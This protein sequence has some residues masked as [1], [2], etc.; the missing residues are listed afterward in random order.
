MGSERRRDYMVNQRVHVL[1]MVTWITSLLLVLASV[2]TGYSLYQLAPRQPAP[3]EIFGL[4]AYAVVGA[5]VFVIVASALTLGVYTIIHTHRMLGSAYHIGMHLAQMNAGQAP[6]NLTLRDGDY[7]QE[8]AEE[9][10][11]MRPRIA[12]P[13]AAPP[14]EPPKA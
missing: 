6:P 4:N 13:A 5:L 14:A 9:I 11:R 10:N 12:P 8:I 7:F 1:Y 3:P 2:V